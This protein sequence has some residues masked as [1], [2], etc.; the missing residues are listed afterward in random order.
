MSID[1]RIASLQS[2]LKENNLDALYISGTD[3][4]LGEYVP[5]R[6][7]SREWITGF[8]GSA[9]TVIV[10]REGCHLWVDSRYYIQGELQI[11]G[12]GV[13]LHLQGM[14]GVADPFDWVRTQNISTLAVDGTTISVDDFRSLKQKIEESTTSL[15]VISDVLDSLW[16]QRPQ[17][18]FSLVREIPVETAGRSRKDKIALL[19]ARLKKEGCE[20]MVITTLDDIAWVTN[21]RGRDLPYTPV[22]YSYLIITLNDALL[23]TDTDRFS[24]ELAASVQEDIAIASYEDIEKKIAE[25]CDI[26]SS[27]LVATSQT[28]LSLFHVIQ[29][30][31]HVKEQ[32]TQISTSEKAKKDPVEIEGFRRAHYL[33]G[34]A[35]VKLLASM[36]TQEE[37]YD[38]ISIARRLEELR[39]ESDEYLFPSFSPIAG[40]GPHGAMEHYSAREGSCSSLEGNSL[41]VL[42]TGGQYLS[43]TTDVTRTLLFGQPSEQMKRDYTLVLKGNLA[44]SKARFPKGTYGYQLDVLARQFLWNRGSTYRHGTGHGVGF[45]LGVHEGPVRI[46]P[47]AIEVP[48]EQGNVISNEPGLY[49]RDAYGIRLENLVTVFEEG[50]T[51]FDTFYTFEVLTL[52]PFERRLIDTSLMSDEEIQLLDAYHQWVYDELSRSLEKEEEQWL[53]K[54]TLPLTV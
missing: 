44:L 48:L 47:A 5:E 15:S 18:P 14:A 35:L 49:R 34:I 2:Y 51:E 29:A 26:S 36:D 30:H 4:H 16:E 13:I 9:G 11:K 17:R 8:T 3:V 24:E 32:K 21:L 7:R 50:T 23:C 52:C 19:R 40:F 53:R 37:K 22:F 20:A 25:L 45:S 43:G 27:V 1:K 39:E 54:A 6:Y 38:E 33:D 28:T 12:T 41:L 42:D 31:A 10:T 46:S